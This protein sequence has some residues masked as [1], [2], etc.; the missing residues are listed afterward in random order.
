MVGFSLSV[1]RKTLA[2]L[3]LSADKPKTSTAVVT[4][5]DDN[6]LGTYSN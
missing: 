2:W 6:Y 5:S 4:V 3:G 1:P